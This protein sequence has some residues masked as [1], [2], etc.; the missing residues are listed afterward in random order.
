MP[1]TLSYIV[2]SFVGGQII[3]MGW[4]I[5][6]VMSSVDKHV[7]AALKQGLEGAF[8]RPVE[9]RVKIGSLDH[10]YDSS[11]M[12]YLS[13]RLLSR[14]DRMK[15]GR[16]DKIVGLVDVDLYSPGFDFVFG[17]ADIAAGVAT[18]SLYRLRQ[19]YYDQ[20]L[21]ANVFEERAIKEAIHELGHLYG[22]GHC[23]NPKC[24]M[25]FSTSLGSVN[26]KTKML[27]AKC[28]QRLRHNQ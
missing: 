8:N 12:Q 26:R 13:P 5:L 11:R 6:I 27:C 17:E 2:V 14:L 23:S 1:V 28:M 19:E 21:D 25:H 4:I 7:L 20:P 10:A 24:V 9:V 15:K 16:G 22:L 3:T 18:V